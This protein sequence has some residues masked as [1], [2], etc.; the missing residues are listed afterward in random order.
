MAG[1]SPFQPHP[2]GFE[3]PVVV[4]EMALLLAP[5]GTW[6]TNPTE[7]AC[8]GAWWVRLYFSYIRGAAGGRFEYRY[9]VS[10]YS[11]DQTAPIESWFRGS[12]YVPGVLAIGADVASNVQRETVNYMAIGDDPETFVSPP[13]HLAGASERFRLFAREHPLGTTPPGVLMVVGVFYVEG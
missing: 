8:A 1:L 3:N 4:R 11:A 2:V 10:P 6:D 9:E 12:L 5:K 13:I 7:I